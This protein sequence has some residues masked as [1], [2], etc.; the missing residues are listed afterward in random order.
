MNVK[1]LFSTLPLAAR[2]P[3]R[4]FRQIAITL[5]RENARKEILIP[6]A[7]RDASRIEDNGRDEEIDFENGLRSYRR[8]SAAQDVL[9]GGISII[10]GER[11]LDWLELSGAGIM[12]D[13]R[14]LMH[15]HVLASSGPENWVRVELLR[16]WKS[17][18]E[19]G[20]GEW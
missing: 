8:K 2:P 16:E 14:T 13:S 6:G 9:Y 5:L 7:P 3:S 19:F 11:V 20:T 4:I 17:W 12:C 1:S 18:A 15:A 10:W